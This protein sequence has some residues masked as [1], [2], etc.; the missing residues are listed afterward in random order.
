MPMPVL[1]VNVFTPFKSTLPAVLKPEVEFTR[2]GAFT[3]SVLLA[4]LLIRARLPTVAVVKLPSPTAT[5]MVSASLPLPIMMPFV[6]RALPTVSTVPAKLALFC[7]RV[8]TVVVAAPRS[9]LPLVPSPSSRTFV[10][11]PSAMVLTPRT[12]MSVYPPAVRAT[13]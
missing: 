6:T 13:M 1:P 11:E 5:P 12:S 9:M 7:S 2:I 3:V 10:V 8:L 4:L